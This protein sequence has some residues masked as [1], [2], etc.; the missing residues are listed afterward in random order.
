MTDLN[1]FEEPLL[2]DPDEEVVSALVSEYGEA[3][4]KKVLNLLMDSTPFQMAASVM[5]FP[6]PLLI[7][8]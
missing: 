6:Y 2:K 8:S 7:C 3:V 4:V 1:L 5:P